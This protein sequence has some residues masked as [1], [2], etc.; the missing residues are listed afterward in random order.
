[1][2]LLY[3]VLSLVPIIEVENRLS[4]AMKIGGLIVISNMIGFAI[5]TAARR[6]I[7]K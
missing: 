4:F 7:A 2:T 1:M 3:V 6:K 5:Y